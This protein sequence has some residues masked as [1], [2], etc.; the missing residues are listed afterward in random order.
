MVVC[1]VRGA[2][3][4]ISATAAAGLFLRLGVGWIGKEF[5]A[6]MFA[7]EIE[8]LSIAVG[9]DRGGLVNGHATDGV[10]SGRCCIVHD[11]LVFLGYLL[12]YRSP[13]A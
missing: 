10:F 3:V 7:A 11:D 8:C 9:V 1:V 2:A 12:S 6:T 4:R 13:T 5:L